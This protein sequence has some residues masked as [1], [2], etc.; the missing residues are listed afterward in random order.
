[1]WR[2]AERLREWNHGWTS[3]YVRLWFNNN[4]DDI[5]PP[6]PEEISSGP[7]PP[8]VISGG[9][10]I[11]PRDVRPVCAGPVYALAATH[12]G[13]RVL[14]SNKEAAV[15]LVNAVVGA[16]IPS[17]QPIANFE[18]VDQ[19]LP[20][21]GREIRPDFHGKADGDCHV[22]IDIQA[23]FE[24]YLHREALLDAACELASGDSLRGGGDPAR[25]PG[26]SAARKVWA[27]QIFNCD[28]R[29][30]PQELGPVVDS[31]APDGIS[32]QAFGEIHVLRIELPQLGMTFPV[33]RE[34]ALL[35][36]PLEWWFYLL[37]FSDRFTAGEI[38]KCRA[39]EKARD[40]LSGLESLR[41]AGWHVEVQR[42]Y[43]DELA[44]A[45]TDF[46]ALEPARSEIERA[47]SLRGELEGQVLGLITCFLL[48]GRMEKEFLRVLTGRI[49]EDLVR[50]M[51]VASKNPKK[52]PDQYWRFLDAL[53]DANQ[54]ID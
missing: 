40:V 14:M 33:D 12:V 5:L 49:T 36:S 9:A 45:I 54:L 41:R 35:W 6:P 28:L 38:E 24:D 19:L 51:W 8:Q 47:A 20:V 15:S 39:F 42:E 53:R 18:A 43:R 29:A 16:A 37:Q 10:D 32:V 50:D 52:T 44:T 46:Q 13:F 7:A 17:F 3:R 2:V 31:L 21:G 22:V 48:A 1:V 4:R 34:V 26:R 23:R 25:A 27:V 30:L 11:R